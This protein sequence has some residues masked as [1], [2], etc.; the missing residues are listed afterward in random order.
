MWVCEDV[1]F[2]KLHSNGAIL[3][4]HA[5]SDPVRMQADVRVCVCVRACVYVCVC[6]ELLLLSA[7]SVTDII[8]NLLSFPSYALCLETIII[9]INVIAPVI[10]LPQL[11]IITIVILLEFDFKLT[12]IFYTKFSI[13]VLYRTNCTL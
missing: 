2:C 8:H 4:S 9:V 7:E 6:S 13:F 1:E 10:L 11:L 3:G 5:L 12:Y